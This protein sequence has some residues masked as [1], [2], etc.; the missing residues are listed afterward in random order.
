MRP[1]LDKAMPEAW[2]AAK[3]YV[4][5]IRTAAV[6]RGLTV[7]EIELINVRCSQLNGCA[8]CLDLH[9]RK[10]RQAGVPAQKLDVLPAW[11]ETGL[12]TSRET[13]VLAIAEAGTVLP[14]NDDRRADLEAAQV[15]LGVD[16]FVA[17]EWVV[18]TINAFNR[19]SI[20]SEYPVR[21]RDADGKVIQ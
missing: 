2:Q 18:V 11:R 16:G 17:A 10:A 13:A 4:E 19:I 5:E 7:P 3:V 21:A 6:A 14:L 8:S 9:S 20:L 12:Y 15:V 1:F